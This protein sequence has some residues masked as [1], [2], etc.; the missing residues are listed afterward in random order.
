M[1]LFYFFRCVLIKIQQWAEL[2]EPV[3]YC[4]YVL[5]VESRAVPSSLAL[6]TRCEGWPVYHTQTHALLTRRGLTLRLMK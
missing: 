3:S 2:N 5:C 6:S 4:R 1:F